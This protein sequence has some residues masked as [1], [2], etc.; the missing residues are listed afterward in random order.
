MWL[1]TTN[2]NGSFPFTDRSQFVE[3]VNEWVD[4][5][6]CCDEDGN[7][8]K[9]YTHSYTGRNSFAWETYEESYQDHTG[10]AFD[11]KS[12]GDIMNF[13]FCG[14]ITGLEILDDGYPNSRSKAEAFYGC[15]GVWLTTTFISSPCHASTSRCH[16]PP[17]PYLMAFHFFPPTQP[18]NSNRLSNSDPQHRHHHHNPRTTF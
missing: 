14:F 9:T 7:G 11:S 5:K 16:T 18:T 10:Y 2:R 12:G 4:D 13:A 3:A 6:E 15:G 17:P 8:V 1:S